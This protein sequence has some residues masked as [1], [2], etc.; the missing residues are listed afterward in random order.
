MGWTF[1][2][3]GY[4]ASYAYG[5]ERHSEDFKEGDN[6]SHAV[7]ANA[8]YSLTERIQLRTTMN[9]TMQEQINVENDVI[10]YVLLLDKIK[11]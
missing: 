8:Q 5:R 7:S 2:R 9:R 3:L 6:N 1:S 10:E 4:S 11:Q